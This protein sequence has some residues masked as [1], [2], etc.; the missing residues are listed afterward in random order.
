MIGR[1]ENIVMKLT[2]VTMNTYLN[3]LNKVSNKVNGKL[4]YYI[5]RNIRKIHNELIEFENIRNDY[6]R[7]YGTVN[8]NGDYFISV[9]SNEYEN[10]LNF[11]SEYASIEHEVDITTVSEKDFFNS[12][13]NAN[14]ILELDFMIKEDT[15]IV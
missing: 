5:A 4:A 15:E 9:N 11:I 1:Q 10:F 12:N 8:E 14:E 13:L 3:S 2:N 6:I 7:K